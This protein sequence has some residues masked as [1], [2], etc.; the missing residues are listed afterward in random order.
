MKVAIVHDY[1]NQAGGAERVVAV[2][3]HMFPEA[4][5]FATLFDPVAVGPPL[6]TADVRASWMRWLPGWRKHFRA[7]MPLYP[8]AVRSFDLRGFD[9]IISSSSAWAKGVRVPPGAL[10]VCYCHT[11]MRWAWSF[12]NYV[13]RSAL[14]PMARFAAGLT[15]P[16][17]RRW[18]VKTARTVD[19]FIANSTEV[20]QRIRATYGRASEIVFPPV[21]V[22]RFRHDRP[23]E[24]FFLV[25]S[26][27]NAYKRIDLAVRAC[28]RHKLPLVVVGDGPERA[29]LAR[30]A[31]PTVRFVGR[32]PD[33]EV[34]SLFE[35]CRAFILP[36]EED[37]GITP[38]E[39]NAAGRPVVAYAR[40]GAL[41]T[42]RDGE[43]GVLFHE[44]SAESLGDALHKARARSWDPA[45][46]RAH[47]ES[48]SEAVFIERFRRALGATLENWRLGRLGADDNN[49]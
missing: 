27:L 38:L 48:F 31:G 30:M 9:V 20:S 17:L 26:R 34:T 29:T 37:F 21:D 8:L 36:G 6:A 15:I 41:D 2:L 19:R 46:L 5:I 39:A 3:H 40:G 25:V 12:D 49:D 42:V 22:S 7:F 28:T 47:A 43:T 18:D 33:A 44:A 45:P 16:A 10:H 23:G 24:D 11:P 32:L 1:L 14:S 4:P 35:T 13:N